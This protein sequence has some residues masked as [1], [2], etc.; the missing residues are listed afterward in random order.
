MS[1]SQDRPTG[2]RSQSHQTK[3][4]HCSLV[5]KSSSVTS[6]MALKHREE[7]ISNHPEIVQLFQVPCPE[8]DEIFLRDCLDLNKHAKEVH[9]NAMFEVKR[10][11]KKSCICKLCDKTFETTGGLN[12]HRHEQH[13]EECLAMGMKMKVKNMQ[14]P[15]CEKLFDYGHF[16]NHIF[17]THRDKR[18][19]HPEIVAEHECDECGEIFIMKNQ[20]KEHLKRFHTAQ[21]TCSICSKMCPNAK[22]L[23]THIHDKHKTA[24]SI[25]C[26]FCSKV[27]DNNAY[28]KEHVKRMHLGISKQFKHECKLCA[29][30]KY[31]TEDKLQQHILDD[32]SGVEYLCDQCPIT[33][34]NATLRNGHLSRVHGQK[35]V[36][37]EQCDMMFFAKG[38]MKAHLNSV[39]LKTKKK[40]CP[41]C[42]ETFNAYSDTD[43]FI[44]HMNRHNNVR[45]FSCEVC[46]KDFLSSG[47]LQKHLRA[48]TRPLQCDQCEQKFSS[49]TDMR[50]HVN[51]IHLGI[52]HECRHGCG[53]QTSLES[54]RGRH[55]KQCRLNPLPGAPWSV[56][57]G[58]ANRYVLETYNASKS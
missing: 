4:N 26:E 46:G 37:C 38:L 18:S 36:K 42:G 29:S 13:L 14:C 25:V 15:Y 55:E 35:N 40:T 12:R 19:L 41:V 8:C 10:R 48:H 6:H 51:R 30:G 21:V 50:R 3:P 16:T 43:G 1:S 20:L 24:G 56:S 34:S 53:L 49:S 2:N 23:E 28:L 11:F 9:G 7:V 27:F 45:P 52:Q 47:A 5:L 22:S 33:F 32:H 39:H 44:A 31:Q 54:N 58:T 57:N 17:Y